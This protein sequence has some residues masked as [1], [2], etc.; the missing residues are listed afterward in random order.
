M[1]EQSSAVN[2]CAQLAERLPNCVNQCV[3]G[4]AIGQVGL[5]GERLYAGVEVAQ[6][7]A[8]D[9]AASAELR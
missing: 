5:E 9:S 6:A 4:I 1:L 8:V 7:A 3:A 2:Q